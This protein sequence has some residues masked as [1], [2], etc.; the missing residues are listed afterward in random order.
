MTLN[1]AKAQISVVIPVWNEKEK[2]IKSFYSSLTGVLTE[3]A[4]AYQIVFID[5]GST[6]GVFDI[7]Y[8]LYQK[9][10]RVT[11]VKLAKNFG[12]APALLAGFE[13]AKGDVIVTMDV[14]FQYSPKELPK[15]IEKIDRNNTLVSGYRMVRRDSFFRRV[16]SFMMNK[17]MNVRTGIKMRDWGCSFVAVRRELV[18]QLKI[19]GRNARFIKPILAK[20]AESFA[21]V[22]VRH[23][24]R[25]D[26]KSKY[27]FLRLA[28]MGIDFLL[29]YSS[30]PSKG[31][32][33]LFIIEKVVGG[34][35]ISSCI[36]H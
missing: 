13:Y 19:V 28:K 18:G 26:S 20:S 5:D 7:L 6:N 35:Q 11:I 17:I 27:N 1:D 23:Y 31:N 32:V 21:E 15:L 4:Q 29:F 2:N 25:K 24:S 10:K 34:L 33:P 30:R 14:D 36:R 22:E 12:Q 8:G 9:D 3:L 16:S